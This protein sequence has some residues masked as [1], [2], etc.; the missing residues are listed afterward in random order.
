M[1]SCKAM[2][3][4]RNWGGVMNIEPMEPNGWQVGRASFSCTSAIIRVVLGGTVLLHTNNSYLMEGISS[5]I[6]R[7]FF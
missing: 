2:P 4:K 6:V 1:A 7:V 3:F 5:A